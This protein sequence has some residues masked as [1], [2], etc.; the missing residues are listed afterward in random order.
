MNASKL[1]DPRFWG[2]A[3][4]SGAVAGADPVLVR[5]VRQMDAHIAQDKKSVLNPITKKF[6]GNPRRLRTVLVHDLGRKLLSKN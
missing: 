1:N 3:A 5:A 2:N 4:A 6:A